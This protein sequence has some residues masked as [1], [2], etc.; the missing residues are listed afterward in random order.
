MSIGYGTSPEK[1]ISQY[2]NLSYALNQ[3]YPNPF[4]PSTSISYSLE[5][6][7]FVSL[8]VYDMLGREVAELVN[9]N[10]PEGNYTV[11]FS[12]KGGSASGGNAANLPSGIYFY[13]IKSGSF[14]DIKKML[15]IK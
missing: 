15:L 14:S 6:D 1:R 8:K 9:E 4:N 11:Q 10:Q 13:Q 2:T 7:D 5:K 12:A 3:N